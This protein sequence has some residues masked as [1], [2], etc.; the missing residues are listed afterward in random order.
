MFSSR[1]PVYSLEWYHI[2]IKI[3]WGSCKQIVYDHFA[4]FR[5]KMCSMS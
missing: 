5:V 1:I 3:G 4:H 2:G